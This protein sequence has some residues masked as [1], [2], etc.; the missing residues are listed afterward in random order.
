MQLWIMNHSDF[1]FITQTVYS[2][3][4]QTFT[5]QIPPPPARAATAELANTVLADP[6]SADNDD[7]LFVRS[8]A[9][10]LRHSH[11]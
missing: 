1:K 3:L 10:I 9:L 5:Q 4:K 7:N 8:S 6:L 11:N 2:T